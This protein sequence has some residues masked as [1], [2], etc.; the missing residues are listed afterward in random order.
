[1]LGRAGR[2][3]PPRIEIV[4]VSL[5]ESCFFLRFFCRE[6]ALLFPTME[7]QIAMHLLMPEIIMILRLSLD[8]VPQGEQTGTLGEKKKETEVHEE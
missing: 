8:D 2:R 3:R 5:F 1:M 6:W 4:V 7:Y